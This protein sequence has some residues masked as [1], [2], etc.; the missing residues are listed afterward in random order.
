MFA[1]ILNLLLMICLGTILIL[2]V[3][4][5]PRIPDESGVKEEKKTYFE[6]WLISELPEKAD[7]Y[8]SNLLAKWIR[9]IRVFIM[10]ADNL[11]GDHLKKMG[12]KN[13]KGESFANGF[14]EMMDGKE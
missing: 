2:V 7:V 11:L 8:L 10:K 14:K 1:F 5:L 3:R 13:G 12:A 9:K 4:V 6:R